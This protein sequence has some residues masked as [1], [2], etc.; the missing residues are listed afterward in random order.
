MIPWQHNCGHQD[1]GWCL[2]CTAELGRSLEQAMITLAA[3]RKIMKPLAA[4]QRFMQIAGPARQ[5]L[6]L[7]KDILPPE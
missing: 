7:L 4:N 1:D 6:N 5:V 2:K 3:I